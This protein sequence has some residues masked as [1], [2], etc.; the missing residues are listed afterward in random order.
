MKKT[1]GRL[2]AVFVSHG[3]P[4]VA[5]QDDAFTRDLSGFGKS[6]LSSCRAIVV[7][8]AHWASAGPVQV[9]S[10]KKSDVIYDFGGF[11]KALYDIPYPAPGS[12]DLA[13]QI[14]NL[15][16]TGGIKA[17]LNPSR[18]IDHGVWIPLLFMRPGADVPVI[19]V[20][21]PLLG[22]PRD[23]LK[24]GKVL[25]PL[26]DEGVLLI[27]SGGA[28]HN[29]AKLKWHAKE[30]AIEPWALEFDTWV[31]R[32]L[33]GA[34]IEALLE[35]ENVGP[36]VDLAHPTHEHFMPIFFTMGASL[37]GDHVKFI[38]EG[39]QYASLSMLSFQLAPS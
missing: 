24:L 39:F 29:L 26:R 27:G 17:E 11:P 25:S 33:T 28:V 4:T 6:E 8:S 16:V 30:G 36:R 5:L 2:P 21:M 37:S 12:P 18:G 23:V 38:H 31:K 3:S 1:L 20:S 7:L 15:C 13:E 9:T 19:Q 22:S 32:N 35:F 10:S 34:N 14:V